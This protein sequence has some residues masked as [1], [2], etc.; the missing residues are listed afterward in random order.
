MKQF[1]GDAG[2]NHESKGGAKNLES[3]YKQEKFE[4]ID[5]NVVEYTG[6]HMCKTIYILYIILNLRTVAVSAFVASSAE[7]RSFWQALSNR[8]VN[9]CQ[10]YRFVCG[11]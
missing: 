11:M 6:I 3:I 5:L 4:K 2:V 9:I 10:N 1:T 7:H 8:E